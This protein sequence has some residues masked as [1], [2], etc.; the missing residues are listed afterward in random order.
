LGWLGVDFWNASL[1]FWGTAS[2]ILLKVNAY[3]KKTPT[4][5]ASITS[6]ISPLVSSGLRLVSST[7]KAAHPPCCR[8]R[9]KWFALAVISHQDYASYRSVDVGSRSACAAAMKSG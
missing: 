5:I 7:S 4:I 1:T 6:I 8:R 2:P 9:Q 3:A